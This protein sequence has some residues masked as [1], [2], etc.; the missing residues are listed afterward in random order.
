MSPVRRKGE[1]RRQAPATTDAVRFVDERLGIS[2]LLRAAMKYIFPDHW[3]FL[4]GEIALYSFLALVAT[5]VYLALFFDPS[6]A[7]VV[8]GG[9][10]APLQGAHITQAYNST[11]DIVFNVP[12]GLLIR[13]THHWAA[14]VFV[15]AIVIH[16]MRVFFTGA[17]RKPRDVNW[18]IGVTLVTLA[19]VEGFAGYSLPDDLLSGM[20]LAIGYSVLLAVPVVGGQLGLLLWD[21][22]FPG[23]G[24]FVDRL[25]IAHVFILPAVLAT[26]IAVHL[27]IIMR[28]KHSQFPGPG[29]TEENVV[30]TPLWP[31]YMLRALGMMTATLAML[32]L[33]GGLVQVNPIWQYGPYEPYLGTNGAQPDWY[34]GWLI[35]ALRLMPGFDLTIGRATIAPNPFF[36]GILFPAVVFG[37]LYLWP[38]AERRITKDFARHD[39]LQR[40][41]DAPART[42]LGAAF[43]TWIFTIFMAGAADRLLVSIGFPY[44]GQV[45][46]FRVLA[47]V[48]PMVVFA[49]TLRLCRELAASEA[50]PLREWEGAVVAQAGDGRYQALEVAPAEGHPE[51]EPVHGPPR[52]PEW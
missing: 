29:R 45:W 5:G 36:G 6:V 9:S 34:M 31:A 30:G 39:L 32:F 51:R 49:F 3:S 26:L 17:F 44:A 33:L 11:L 13:Q 38:A 41:R 52:R 28:Q 37:V 2:P 27:A 18:L 48:A 15:V 24:A 4:F 47:V 19:I 46:F 23:S 43:F 42:A 12:A 25:F 20:G 14:L 16:L 1:Q 50:T 7:P 22:P 8:Y 35:G 21:G 10:Y 40:P